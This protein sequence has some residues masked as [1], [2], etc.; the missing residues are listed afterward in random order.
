VR[1]TPTRRTAETAELAEASEEE[2]E[3]AEATVS[4]PLE[5]EE[6]PRAEPWPASRAE[7]LPAP[8]EFVP[9]PYHRSRLGP[10]VLA[11]LGALLAVGAV[12]ALAIA[13]VGGGSEGGEGTEIQRAASG[14]GGGAAGDGGGRQEEAAP[15]GEGT[16]G[17]A[18][19]PASDTPNPAAGAALND[20]GYA[21]LNAG[22]PEAAIPILQRAVASFPEGSTDLEYGYALYNLGDAL[23]QAGRPEEAIPILE[24]RLQIPDQIP[25]VQAKLEE[26]HAAAEE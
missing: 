13:L 24:A 10:R 20:R 4:T 3:T 25:E 1:K 22:D 15:A 21:V 11:V 8:G 6:T 9:E 5:R 23:V 12:V 17:S 14:D 18:L 7:P 26:A 2:P 16:G 19:P